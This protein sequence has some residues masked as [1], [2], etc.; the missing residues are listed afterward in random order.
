[1]RPLYQVLRRK[2]GT[3]ALRRAKQ[4]Q[5]RR[6][7]E[8]RHAVPRRYDQSNMSD[9][10]SAFAALSAKSENEI[11]LKTW[12]ND[13]ILRTLSTRQTSFENRFGKSRDEEKMLAAKKLMP[14]SLFNF[15]FR[16]TAKSFS[17]RWQSSSSISYPSVAILAQ[18]A[19]GR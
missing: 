8:A 4:T 12:T 16:G 3:E 7:F 11:G 10:N 17:L 6:G 19:V 15:R 5:R 18:V 13:D 2:T 14:E 9:E 1:M